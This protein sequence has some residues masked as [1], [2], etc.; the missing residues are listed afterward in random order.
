MDLTDS[1]LVQHR[2]KLLDGNDGS[3]DDI[4][5]PVHMLDP[6]LEIDVTAGWSMKGVRQRTTRHIADSIEDSR[7]CDQILAYA[8]QQLSS[9]RCAQATPEQA[10]L[11]ARIQQSAEAH[12][13]DPDSVHGVICTD[14]RTG[15]DNFTARFVF[16]L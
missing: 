15:L 11:L 16:Y 2:K 13:I 7:D 8:K 5:E 4:L 9:L 1:G 6:T 12:G 14:E 3:L 10:N